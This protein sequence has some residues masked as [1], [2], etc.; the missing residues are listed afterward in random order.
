MLKNNELIDS[1]LED[2]DTM[3][4]CISLNNSDQEHQC[5]QSSVS[6]DTSLKYICDDT[7]TFTQGTPEPTSCQSL[8]H[9]GSDNKP[10]GESEDEDNGT[11]FTPE[12]H[13]HQENIYQA[14]IEAG[15][16]IRTN[17]Q[18]H[19]HQMR[20]SSDGG[21]LNDMPSNLRSLTLH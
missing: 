15:N 6:C 11:M 4:S 5:Q 10:M 14:K 16:L 8:Q 17:K 20:L 1:H 21:H 18:G 13:Q 19:P 3:F 12:C 7:N 2:K 9:Q